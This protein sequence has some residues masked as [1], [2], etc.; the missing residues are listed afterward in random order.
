MFLIYTVGKPGVVNNTEAANAGK[1]MAIVG[2]NRIASTIYEKPELLNLQQENLAG[3]L[4]IDPITEEVNL[5]KFPNLLGDVTRLKEICA[6]HDI[7]KVILAIDPK[8]IQKLHTV[9]QICERNNI[10]YE[11]LS[12]SF[13]V[14]YDNAFEK[15]FKEAPT[16]LPSEYWL[17]RSLDILFSTIMFLMFLPSYFLIALAIKLESKGPVLYSQERVGK[18]G[19]LFRIY[20]FR[21]MYVDA[22]KYSGPQLATQNDPRIT[23]VGRFARKTR[24]DELPQ[25]INVL[26]GD[27]SLVGPRPER[28]YFVDKYTKEIPNYKDRLSGKTGFDRPCASRKRL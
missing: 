10:S 2:I 6:K 18:D 24:L 28:P 9:I 3:F 27:M 22:E 13:E 8:D 15:I 12:D 23:K 1:K 17:Q 5:E 7:C 14:N 19:H 4:N 16:E 20:K 25:L 21:S 26:R 11:L